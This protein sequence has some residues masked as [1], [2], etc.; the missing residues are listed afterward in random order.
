VPSEDLTSIPGL[1]ENH[2]RALASKLGITS[3]RALADADQRD[4]YDA[5]LNTRPRPSLTRIAAW[6]RAARSRLSEA[7]IDRSAW[8]TAASFAVIFAQRRVDGGWERRLEAEQTEVEPEPA[9]RQWPGWDCEPLCDWMRGQL[10]PPQ[11]Q[12]EPEAGAASETGVTHGAEP[13]ERAAPT[14]AG[15]AELRIDS[16]TITDGSHELDLITA[17][18]LTGTPPEDLTPPVRLNL[19]VSGGRSGQQL[20]AAAWFRRQAGP[21]WTPHE[22][23]AIS[24]SGQAEFDLSSVPPGE[25]QVRLLAW[26]TDAGAT[27]AAVTLPRLTF[28]LE[29]DQDGDPA[30]AGP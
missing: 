24:P 16:A 13:A 3:M 19:T 20:Q 25:H 10:S 11:D 22:P 15:R 9:H 12:T 8:H 17:G 7:A 2:A 6:Q 30:V 23:A 29:V 18:D 5:L 26:A 21:G 28:R 14:P 1:Q 4:I 27:I